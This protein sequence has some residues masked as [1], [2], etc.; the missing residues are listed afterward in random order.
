MISPLRAQIIQYNLQQIG[1]SLTEDAENARSL[2]RMVEM[3][4]E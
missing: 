2:E 3:L 1:L 4:L